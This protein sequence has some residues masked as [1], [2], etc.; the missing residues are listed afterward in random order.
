[1]QRVFKVKHHSNERG[2][3]A[4]PV[5]SSDCVSD[6]LITGKVILA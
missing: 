4:R 2:S 3:A 6:C 1:M 5:P